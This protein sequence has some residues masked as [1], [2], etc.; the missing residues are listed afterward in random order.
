LRSAYPRHECDTRQKR[1]FVLYATPSEAPLRI[2]QRLHGQDLRRHC[3]NKRNLLLNLGCGAVT[4]SGWV[5]ID[6]S[7]KSSNV[8]Y[9]DARNSLPIESGTVR[10][11]HS[12][13]FLEYLSYHELLALLQ[14]CWRVLQ[15]EGTMRAIVPDLEKYARA[16]CANDLSFFDQLRFLGGAVERLETNAMVCNQSFRMGGAHNFAW[17]FETFARAAKLSNFS[18]C[19]KSTIHDVDPSLDIDGTDYWRPLESLYVNLRK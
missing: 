14:E 3:V 12:E 10:H 13:A 1:H 16:Y 6:A 17:D 4:P 8:F 18:N 19:V 2:F 5:N 9:W 15:P 7:P 11:V